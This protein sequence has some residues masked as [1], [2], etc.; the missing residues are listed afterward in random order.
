MVLL[1]PSYTAEI[2]K[3][4]AHRDFVNSLLLS[5]QFRLPTHKASETRPPQTSPPRQEMRWWCPRTLPHFR[6]RCQMMRRQP[7]SGSPEPRLRAM[8][9]HSALRCAPRARSG[10][11]PRAF[12][13]GHSATHS[14][15]PMPFLMHL[16]D[17]FRCQMM[18]RQPRSGSP[19]PRLRAMLTHSALRC[20]PRA[21]SGR[22]PRAFG[23]GIRP[24]IATGRCHF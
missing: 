9:T 8:L 18:R 3:G 13:R 24:L 11:A 1:L 14:H 6:F 7:R 5:S 19:E 17:F 23:R 22:A 21:R 16:C 2:K 12:G 20:A 4:R 15:R 10:R